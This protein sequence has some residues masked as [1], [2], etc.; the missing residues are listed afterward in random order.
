VTKLLTLMLAV[1]LSFALA[2]PALSLTD[3][4]TRGRVCG[5]KCPQRRL[6]TFG[7]YV[8]KGRTKP[9]KRGQ[10]VRFYFRRKGKSEW[11]QFGKYSTTGVNPAFRSL[12]ANRRY[13][14]IRSHRWRVTFAP[15]RAGRW[16][17]KAKFLKQNGYA[18]SSVRKRVRVVYSE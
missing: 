7:G 2:A 15:Y 11:H 16:I 12:N 17:L 5:H 8:F 1:F 13:A 9:S 14:K 6:E 10:V 3:T 18:S 4:T